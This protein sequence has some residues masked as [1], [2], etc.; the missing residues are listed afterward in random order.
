[1][2]HHAGSD[3][4]LFTRAQLDGP[5]TRSPIQAAVLRK[6]MTT[7]NRRWLHMPMATVLEMPAG[8]N[9]FAFD[10]FL[11][12]L[13]VAYLRT[14]EDRYLEHAVRLV[15]V[16]PTEWRK[17]P[18][19]RD[20]F[21]PCMV[22]ALVKFDSLVGAHL[23]VEDRGILTGL[24]AEIA[25]HI[26]SDFDR[27]D[28]GQ[29]D[30]TPWNHA[31]MVSAGIGLAGL[32]LPDHPDGPAWFESG[33]ARFTS[34]LEVG[35]TDAGMTWEGLHYCGYV[36][37]LLGPLLNGLRLGGH[38]DLV[39]AEGS[40]AR[41]KLHRVPEWYAHELW[42]GG[43][44]LQNYNDSHWDPHGPLLGFLTT[45][46][47]YEPE[48]CAAVWT[49]L[50]GD[51]GCASYGSNRRF[52]SLADSVLFLPDLEPDPAV[53]ARLPLD[54]H[55][56]EVGYVVARDRW[57]PDASVLAF[58]CGPSPFEVH[59]QSDN[60][61]FTY[62]SRGQP[63][64]LDAGGANL[65]VEGSPSVSD[66]HNL[67]FVDGRAE[68]PAGQGVCIAGSI[69]AVESSE[70]STSIVAE[71]AASYGHGG[72]NP[73]DHA[74][75]QC[76]FVRSPTPYLL[77]FDDL[78]KDRD[79]HRYEHRL[80]VSMAPVDRGGGTVELWRGLVVEGAPSDPGLTT[81]A[82]LHPP[83]VEIAFGTF[84]AMSRPFR[85]HS[86][87]AFA[88]R[89][90]NP[91][92]VTLFVAGDGADTLIGSEVERNGHAVTV[93]LRWPT[94]TDEV[95]FVLYDA[96][97]RMTLPAPSLTRRPV[98]VRVAP[99][100]VG[101]G[102]TIEPAPPLPNFLIIGAQKSATRWLRTVLG[103]HPDIY[104]APREIMYFSN[105]A[106]VVDD[107][108]DWYRE[109]FTGW[110]GERI[111]GEAST[112]YM[113]FNRHPDQL[114][115]RINSLLPDVRLIALLRN[116]VDRTRSAFIHHIRSGRIPAD[117][118][119]MDHVRSVDPETDPLM[120]IS[121]S[122][123]GA[124]LRRFVE[125]F[126]DR[127]LLLLHDDIKTDAAGVY[128]RALEHLGAEAGFEPPSLHAVVGGSPADTPRCD[129]TP[130]EQAEI[131]EYIRDDVA[132]LEAMTGLD[133]SHWG[134]AHP[135]GG[136]SGGGAGG[137][138]S[139][140]VATPSPGAVVKVFRDIADRVPGRRARLA[141]GRRT[142]RRGQEGGRRQT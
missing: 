2:V 6:L 78:R 20:L 47:H 72:Y 21:D 61:S 90:V 98:D 73:V 96:V 89:A 103:E 138:Q 76:I 130:A 123:Y 29:P 83:D 112:S 140:T 100:D 63:V 88:T 42:P 19:D 104:A 25:E 27:R 132:R 94:G 14:G 37:R 129:P 133:L 9:L 101:A 108:P 13:G 26:W 84:D 18:K 80:H 45:F 117:A 126:G 91:E 121:G 92:M 52:S 97:R 35:V 5:P 3:S 95:R 135:I 106:Q 113:A 8:R 54:F 59:D 87:V 10:A 43:S 74:V 32:A 119:L 79:E 57:A 28:Y 24:I 62:V 60:L 36:F 1:M 111:V 107:G 131:Y 46:A 137:P 99:R 110:A 65:G 81:V 70:S 40:A 127:L 102:A 56:K 118:D 93:R 17:V 85:S 134:P 49:M 23:G 75:R 33:V 41:R 116:P 69:I 30:R 71:A 82:V 109:Q 125:I 38:E 48:L 68:A 7:C 12:D 120:L 4:L 136:P 115:E 114:A 16:L 139:P 66:G 15:R 22:A 77:V 39:A 86:T 53:L 11:M 31:I 44:W 105:P 67:V 58:N 122:W 50:V 51:H 141:I 34:F 55:C 142:G 128:R 124:C 64:V